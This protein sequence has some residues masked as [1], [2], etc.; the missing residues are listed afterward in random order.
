MRA[1]PWLKSGCTAAIAAAAWL[2]AQAGWAL[3]GPSFF[4]YWPLSRRWGLSL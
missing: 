2:S 3:V 1:T 4:V